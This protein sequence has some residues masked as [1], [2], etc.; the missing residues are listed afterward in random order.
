VALSDWRKLFAD[1][2]AIPPDSSINTRR[3]RGADF[4]RALYGMFQEAGMDPRSR[5]RP[6]GEEIDGSFRYR[7][8]IMLFEAKWT[9]EAIPASTLYQFR[10]KL[11]GKLVGTLGVFISMGGYS[12]DAV[13]ALVAGKTVNI[14]LLDGEDMQKLATPNCINIEAALDL[15]LRAAAEVG[16]PYVPLPPCLSAS[17]RPP[18]GAQVVIVEGKY[19]AAIVHALLQVA[20]TKGSSPTVVA[21]HGIL[22]L[23]L[24]ALAQLSM[25]ADGRKVVIVA[26][27]DG[28]AAEVRRQI[29]EILSSAALP[30]YVDIVVI[31]ID[32]DLASALGINR[33]R[34][35][36]DEIAQRIQH[37]NLNS[38]VAINPALQKL[39]EELG[40]SRTDHTN[41]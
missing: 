26:D 27:G 39:F 38:L 22:N 28:A 31:V 36:P 9:N 16:T 35:P 11:E 14:I 8:R 12:E 20:G 13:D 30:P 33:R 37:E 2:E 4:E 32:S 41:P 18:S 25:R 34:T 3:R 21:A 6:S 15:K 7:G 10:G 1:L 17:G 24:V 23:P 40:L 5:F 29:N 19:D